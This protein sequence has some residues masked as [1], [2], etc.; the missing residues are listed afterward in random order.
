MK[1]LFFAALGFLLIGCQKEEHVPYYPVSAQLIDFYNFK[2]GSYWIMED[3]Y[4]HVRDSFAVEDYVKYTSTSSSGVDETIVIKILDYPL[5]RSADP[6]IWYLDLSYPYPAGLRL[7]DRTNFNVPRAV[8]HWLSSPPNLA[9]KP[10]YEQG[11]K[12]FENA[13]ESN[14]VY[15]SYNNPQNPQVPDTLAYLTSVFNKEAGMIR[16]KTQIDPDY[17]YDW[18]LVESKIVR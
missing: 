1:H 10:V 3:A 8:F 2:K 17:N 9:N 5:W 18:Q 16:L 7:K 13:Y 15:T 4:T 11:G 6:E 14:C 12:R